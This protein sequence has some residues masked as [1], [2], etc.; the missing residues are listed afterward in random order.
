M[1]VQK[2][3]RTMR[4]VFCMYR[5]TITTFMKRH[6]LIING[7]SEFAPIVTFVL[8]AEFLG[9]MPAVGLLALASVTVL[10]LEWSVSRRIPKFGLIASV[11]ILFFSGLSIVTGSEFFII[12]KD[13]LYTLTFAV[14][15][16]VGLLCNQLFLKAL[17]GDFFAMTEHGWRVL[18]MRWIA[19]FL[20]LALSNEIAR[21][22]LVPTVW[23][24]YK[25]IAVLFTW[26]FG[27]YQ[28][29]LARAERLPEANEWGL[30]IRA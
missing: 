28:F 11:L 24:Y 18:T 3:V 26:V 13:T 8:A 1:A 2:T 21:T 16:G 17:F 12:L 4:T 6:E 14:I 9:F 15:L 29:K 20:I 30:R 7:I 25:L 23:I 22:Q 27:F 19:W 10:I 5:A